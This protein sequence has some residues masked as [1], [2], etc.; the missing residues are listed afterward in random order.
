MAKITST[1]ARVDVIKRLD[2]LRSEEILHRSACGTMH[3][4]ENGDD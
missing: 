4:Y 3:K 2:S 1:D